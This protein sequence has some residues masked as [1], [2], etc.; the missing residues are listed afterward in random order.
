[1]N[2]LWG[3]ISVIFLPKCLARTGF[4]DFLSKYFVQTNFWH[5]RSRAK[6]WLLWGPDLSLEA[7]CM[8]EFQ[9]IEQHIYS[10]QKIS[11]FFA[12]KKKKVINIKASTKYKKAKD[13]LAS[14]GKRWYD[15]KQS[16]YGGESK[17]RFHKQNVLW[18]QSGKQNKAENKC[19][20]IKS[21]DQTKHSWSGKKK[22]RLN[23]R[24]WCDHHAQ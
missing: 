24:E 17:P 6:V 5:S 11:F 20:C 23:T 14:Q 10:I 2:S 8:V 13:S 21:V 19:P 16:D 7:F 12:K 3:L 1:M 22:I 15:R 4:C 9:E 18:W